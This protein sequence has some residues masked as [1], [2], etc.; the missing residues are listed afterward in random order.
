MTVFFMLIHVVVCILL[1]TIILMQ[2]GRGGGLTESFASAGESMFGAKTNSVLV[3]GTAILASVFLLTCVVL[4]HFSATNDRSLMNQRPVSEI[5]VSPA[6]ETTPPV[7]NTTTPDQAVTN[8]VVNPT[9][10]AVH[11]EEPGVE[12]NPQAQTAPEP[13]PVPA[14]AAPGAQ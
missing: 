11:T 5:P 4:A 2:S 14:G 6:G 9:N 7:D 1:A 3:K 10:T 12:S 8:S 13:A